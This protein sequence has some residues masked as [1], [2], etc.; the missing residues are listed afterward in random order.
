[1]NNDFAVDFEKEKQRELMED[2]IPEGRRLFTIYNM[3][4]ASENVSPKGK[5]RDSDFTIRVVMQLKDVETGLLTTRLL[6]NEHSIP[7]SGIYIY[8]VGSLSNLTE[9]GRM[10]QQIGV[11][12]RSGVFHARENGKKVFK[13]HE[14]GGP[15]GMP[16]AADVVHVMEPKM[17]LRKDAVKNKY[18]KYDS[19]A[20][21]NVIDEEG[22]VV[23]E[24]RD[25]IV[26]TTPNEA[27][28]FKAKIKCG[29][30]LF[31]KLT[32]EE[33]EIRGNYFV[34]GQDNVNDEYYDQNEQSENRDLE[35]K[36][37]F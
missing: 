31:K 10:M 26:C 6:K 14:E 22:N 2:I 27:D 37:K 9:Y 30:P 32:E 19:D 13:G 16:V 29:F 18:N 20:F 36:V 8:S 11:K 15:L 24:K 5:K 1:M 35:D 7:G 25:Y 3:F 12:G 4:F 34:F 23:M 17:T 28:D 33:A 21:M